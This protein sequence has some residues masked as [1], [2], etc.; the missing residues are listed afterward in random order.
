MFAFEPK[1]R[2]YDVF[3]LGHRFSVVNAYIIAGLARLLINALFS[4]FGEARTSAGSRSV[5]SGQPNGNV[6][7]LMNLFRLTRNREAPILHCHANERALIGRSGP[8]E[9]PATVPYAE[10]RNL[11]LFSRGTVKLVNGT[12]SVSGQNKYGPLVNNARASTKK[13]LHHPSKRMGPTIEEVV[14]RGASNPINNINA[15]LI[16][17]YGGRRRDGREPYRY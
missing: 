10:M 13:R 2:V 14:K 7:F 8:F 17:I 3:P 9:Y 6:L 4:R 16:D 12:P 15:D 5:C 11:S 1:P